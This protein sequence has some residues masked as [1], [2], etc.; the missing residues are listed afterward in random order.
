MCR[1]FGIV[2]APADRFP[3]PSAIYDMRELQNSPDGGVGPYQAGA[4]RTT[5]KHI[6]G[7]SHDERDVDDD[8]GNYDESED[9]YRGYDDDE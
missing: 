7:H 2:T 8:D 1:E 6:C 4:P 5:N 9:S 3:L